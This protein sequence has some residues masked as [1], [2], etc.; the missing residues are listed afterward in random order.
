MNRFD[1]YM[2]LLMDLGEYTSNKAAEI[3]R[4]E[5]KGCRSE[6]ERDH[7][8]YMLLEKRRHD[9]GYAPGQEW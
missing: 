6:R 2:M 3:Y 5:L 9:L 1:R 7:K 4:K 8:C